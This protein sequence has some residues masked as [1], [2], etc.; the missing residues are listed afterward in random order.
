MINIFL[1]I[2]GAGGI[3]LYTISTIFIYDF[4]YRRNDKTPGFLSVNF[5]IIKFVGKYKK[6]TKSETRRVGVLY[7]FWIASILIVLLSLLLL[8]LA[9]VVVMLY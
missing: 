6:I 4:H 3:A 7:Y 1:I 2:I 8:F 5:H 9:N